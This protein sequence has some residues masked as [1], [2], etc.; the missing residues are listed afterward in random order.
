MKTSFYFIVWILI[1]P[2]LGLFHNSFIN[3]NAFIVALLA[4]W[5]LSWLLN[6][7][8]PETLSYERATHT[9]PLLEYVYTGNIGGFRKHVTR[10]GNNK[11]I[12]F[13]NKQKNHFVA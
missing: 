4:V 12:F 1:Y 5:G 9:A 7:T 11:G 2:L 13:L 8:M 3:Q 6:R 10:T